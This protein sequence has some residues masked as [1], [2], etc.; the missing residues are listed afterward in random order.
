[1][2]VKITGNVIT[3]CSEIN[4]DDLKT[5]GPIYCTDGGKKV[6]GCSASE[7]PSFTEAGISFTFKDAEGNA[8]LNIIA[9]TAGEELK[10]AFVD[11]HH[12]ELNLFM[13]Y[14]PEIQGLIAFDKVSRDDLMNVIEVL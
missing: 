14:E 10:K 7:I 6:Y 4:F 11:D 2:K 3:I 9:D 12:R 8:C 5:L 13:L 1:M